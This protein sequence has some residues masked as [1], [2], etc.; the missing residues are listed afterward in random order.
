MLQA[1]LEDFP[2]ARRFDYLDY[3]R[4]A[5]TGGH[6]PPLQAIRHCA[7][8][9]LRGGM[10]QFLIIYADKLDEF[11]TR[12]GLQQLRQRAEQDD[13][14]VLTLDRGK[15]TTYP[16]AEQASGLLSGPDFSAIIAV[17]SCFYSELLADD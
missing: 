9:A 14:C 11:P 12:A 13:W 8:K 6:S 15:I 5:E 10:K 17:H 3:D 2:A 16:K 4:F 7:Q 1:R